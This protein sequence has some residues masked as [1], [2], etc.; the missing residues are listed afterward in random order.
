[1]LPDNDFGKS[2]KPHFFIK[3]NTTMKK[4]SIFF[5]FALPLAVAAQS[6]SP[7][8]VA[9]AGN[10]ASAG[11]VQLSYT[12]GEVAVTTATGGSSILTQGFHQ[13]VD[14][15]VGITEGTFEGRINVFPNPANREVFVEAASDYQSI[16]GVLTD[17]QGKVVKEFTMLGTEKTSIDVESYAAAT[18]HLSLSGA[19]NKFRKT[20]TLI[21]NR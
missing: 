13:P 15:S 8:V 17:M 9:S 3:N 2:F 18:Y 16:K 11:T 6:L 10:H 20:F 14:V 21:I 12:V 19:D 4:Q 1:L 5:V 7:T